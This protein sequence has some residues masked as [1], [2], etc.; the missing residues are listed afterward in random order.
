MHDILEFNS[1]EI[2]EIDIR[3]PLETELVCK[4]HEAAESGGPPLA[5]L[6]D[7]SEDLPFE[8]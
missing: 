1:G 5:F 3:P 6:E 2:M 8:L 4:K 7:D